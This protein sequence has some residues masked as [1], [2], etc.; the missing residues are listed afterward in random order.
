MGDIQERDEQA[1]PVNPKPAVVIDGSFAEGGGQILR[2]AIAFSLITGTAFVIKDIR[3]N[4]PVPGLRAQHK[5][6]ID[7]ARALWDIKTEGAQV[8][9]REVHF[10]PGRLSARKAEI[11][12][13][14]AGSLTL[15]LQAVLPAILAQDKTITLELKGGTDVRW[16]MPVDYFSQVLL[17]MLAPWGDIDFRLKKRGYYPKGG[18]EAHLRVTPKATRK[19]LDLVSPGT[20]AAI[21]GLSHASSTLVG[22]AERQTQGALSIL[23]RS[24]H[25]ACMTCSYGETLSEGSGLTLW[26]IYSRGEDLTGSYR[27]G[28]DMLAEKGA[29]AE[30]TGES[31]GEALLAS[32]GGMMDEHASDSILPYLALFGG[33]ARIA[34]FTGH[35]K[36]SIYTI[37]KMTGLPFSIEGTIVATPG[38]RA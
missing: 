24:G 20:L 5:A 30:K 3:A 21:K 6:A 10:V 16:S 35:V 32:M 19:P 14:T 22:V 28:S 25:E 34:S 1:S 4:R 38:L 9:S 23:R 18:G 7:A 27:I 11:D 12:I 13:G 36:S 26:A 33:R 15:L 37:E 8:G 31:A 29:R 2:V 17:P